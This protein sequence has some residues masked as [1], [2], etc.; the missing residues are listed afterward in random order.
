MTRDE[1]KLIIR[2]ITASYPNYKPNDLSSTVDVWATMLVDY[3]YEGI[4]LAL[5]AYITTDTSGFAPA[6]GQLIAKYNE[7]KN[8]AQMNTMEAWSLVSK[9]L[10]NGYYNSKGEFDKLP[11]LVQKAVGSPE[12]L[13]HWS[14]TDEA[15]VE[16]VI[17]SNFKKSY[18]TECKRERELQA[19]PLT[20]RTMIEG[21]N[22]KMLVANE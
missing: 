14:M 2:A 1:T 20:I 15:E 16:T 7:L 5:Q 21:V 6:I 9:A 8:P 19:M 17:A 13:F 12:N 22:Q 3:D 10:R 18:E 4:S 11:P